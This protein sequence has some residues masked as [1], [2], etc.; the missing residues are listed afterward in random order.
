M[1]AGYSGTPLVKKLGIKDGH[2][3][4]FINIPDYYFDLFEKMPDIEVV[5]E[6][7]SDINFIHFFCK[8]SS[9]LIRYFPRLKEMMD[10]EG[11]LWVSWP[12]KTSQVETD[13]D[14][15]LVRRT[16]LDNGLVDVKV[17]AVDKTWSGLKFVFRKQ[18]RR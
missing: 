10:I 12:K 4:C 5:S 14:G 1:P 11:L 16:G 6:K 2:K 15:N 13:V 7:G 18:D 3:V 8:E 9:E 17:C